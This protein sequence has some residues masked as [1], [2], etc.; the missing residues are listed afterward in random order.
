MNLS[1]LSVNRPVTAW[2]LILVAVILGAVSLVLLP[3]DL[4]P[5]IEVPVV[6]VMVDYSGVAPE[7]I[8]TLIT[9]PIE[10]AVARVSDLKDVSSI[11][12]EGSSVVVAQFEYG[13]DMDFA[14][15]EMREKVDMIK[16]FLP[17]DASTPLILK[18]DPNAFPVMLLGVSSSMETG[19]LQSLIEDEISSRFER[20]DGVASVDL[21]GDNEKEVKIQID[22]GKMTGYG[23][24]M[25]QIKNILRA[26]NLNLP[27]GRIN[28]GSKELLLRSMGEFKTLDDIKDIP[29]V[30]KNGEIIKLSDIATVALGYQDKDSI[31]RVDKRNSIGI[32]ITKQSVANTVKVSKKVL[33]EISAIEKDYPQLK[34]K[35]GMDQADFI[36]KSISNVAQNAIIGGI[37]AVIILYLFLRNMRSTFIVGIAIPISMVSTFALM[38]FGNLTINLVSLG[39]LALGVGMLVDNSIVVLENIYRLR[40]NGYSKKE[41]AIEGAK[42][43]GM[44]V[45]ASTLTTIAVFLPIVFVEGLTS[46]LFKQLSFTVTFS[47]LASLLV[48]LTVVPVLSSQ[49]LEVGEVKERKRRGFSLGRILDLFSKLIQKISDMYIKILH[50]TLHHKTITVLGAVVLLIGSGVLASMVGGEFFPKEDEGSFTVTIE[51]PYGTSLEESDKIVGEVENIIKKIPEKETIVSTIGSQ[52]SFTQS[53]SNTSSI[54]VKLIEQKDRN[55]T[56]EQ[57]VNEV[58]KKVENIVGADITVSESSSMMGGGG[59][60]SAAIEI[61]VKGDDISVLKTIGEDF[62]NIV[63]SIPGTSEVDVDTEEGDPEVRVKINRKA[64]SFYGITAHNLSSILSASVDGVKATTYKVDGDEIDVNLS[65]QET[66]KD[67]VENMKQILIPS[68]KG[69]FVP[70][71]QIA[72]IEYGNSPTQISRMNQIRTVT[73][74][75]QLSGKD[76]KTVTKQIEEK[77]NTYP[78]PSGYTYNFS[79][80]QKDMI[81]AFSSLGKALI[82]SVILIYMILASQFES[83]I[84]PFT[85]MFSVP[86]A[87]S[88]GFIALFLTGRA[89]SVPAFIGFIVLAGIVVNNAIVLIDY[90][91]QLRA[92][93]YERE[94]AILEATAHRFRPIMMTTLTT[95]LGLVPLAL[96]IGEGGTTQAPLATV[97]VG[98]LILSTVLTL[99]FIPVVYT[100]FDIIIEKIKMRSQKKN[101]KK[102][103]SQNEQG[104]L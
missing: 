11:S 77:L 46:I 36:D 98:G 34:I 83:L 39:G 68:S 99:A 13:T 93:G 56:T 38:Y 81:E 44:A 85:V 63:K 32:G 90:I 3:I 28:K 14:A 69:E 12:R 96:G 64:A 84:H 75:S 70:V 10:E 20:I 18:I 41:A 53:G 79:G 19:K 101:K 65:L 45:F 58:R 24:S 55:R 80:Q 86:F 26:E 94:K 66:V 1:K 17:D 72:D 42:G 29:I 16:G 87:L 21:Y 54:M 47:L 4:Y 49:I 104:N 48:A 73:I 5:E 100:I 71:G 103:A 92:I 67:S 25:E 9:K 8:E 2:M 40:E 59:M 78:L 37:L 23:L 89:L 91:N 33:N 57:I 74:S 43:V 15:L 7:E 50:F 82:L 76:L 6:I 95:V 22:Q 35:V 27:G 31:F 60:S 62:K 51:L 61:E 102:L 88:G 30:L 97:V 52:L